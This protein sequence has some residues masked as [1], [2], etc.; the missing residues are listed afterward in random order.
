MAKTVSVIVT[1]DID[2]SP[3]AE[4]M[5]FSFSGHTYEIDLGPDNQRRMREALQPFIDAGRITGLRTPRR[6]APRRTD[7][8]A[9][10]AWALDQGLQISER[11][12]ISA[13]VIS[14]Y[15]ASH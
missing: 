15:D 5:T 1:D 11:G 2:G 12:R 14:K 13:E 4:A 9:V 6:A 7:L 10:R 3:G 8:A